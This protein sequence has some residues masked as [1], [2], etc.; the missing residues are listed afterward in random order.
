[1]EGENLI[2]VEV[3]QSSENNDDL[4]FD[5]ELSTV[6]GETSDVIA[7]EI[8]VAPGTVLKSRCWNGTEWSAI[9]EVDLT[10]W[11]SPSDLRNAVHLH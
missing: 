7:G 10:V 2:A 11:A 6:A 3:H 5:L 1:M 4:Y 8:T 9:A